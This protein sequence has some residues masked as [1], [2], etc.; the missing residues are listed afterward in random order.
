MI[1][2]ASESDDRY[3]SMG[4]LILV[5]GFFYPPPESIYARLM[6]LDFYMEMRRRAD[7][8]GIKPWVFNACMVGELRKALTE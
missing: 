5:S 1:D 2:L 8:C 7:R 6:D 3:L 4:E